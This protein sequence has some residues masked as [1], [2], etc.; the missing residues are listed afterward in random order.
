MAFSPA[1]R[2]VNIFP[3]NVSAKIYTVA[4]I[5]EFYP[6]NILIFFH[7]KICLAKL[8]QCCLYQ[9]SD[10]AVMT[11]KNSTIPLMIMELLNTLKP[12]RY[13][14]TF[15]ES[16]EPISQDSVVFSPAKNSKNISPGNFHHYTARAFWVGRATC[17]IH[18]IFPRP[19]ARKESN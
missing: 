12:S 7:F 18:L 6:T 16:T 1:K 3:G 9:M 10:G 5:T 14:L 17:T 8:V 15:D 13:H 19:P 4:E 2:I 11:P